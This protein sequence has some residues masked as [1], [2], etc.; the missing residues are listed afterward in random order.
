MLLIKRQADRA[1]SES[2]ACSMFLNQKD[3]WSKHGTRML[4]TQRRKWR[5]DTIKPAQQRVEF[6]CFVMKVVS[7]ND[8]VSRLCQPVKK[9]DFFV[10]RKLDNK[11]S[12]FF[13]SIT[14]SDSDRVIHVHTWTKLKI[15]IALLTYTFLVA[16]S[17]FCFRLICNFASS[18]S[19]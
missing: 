11:S 3:R 8:C 7:A 10:R 4:E 14:T 17:S 9:S 5:N 12:S 6:K 13:F 1:L 16:F 2:K 18:K 15:I 19:V